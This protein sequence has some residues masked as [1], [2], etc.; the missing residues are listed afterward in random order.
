MDKKIAGLLGAVGALAAIDA[1][2][3][4]IPVNHDP[5]GS[6]KAGSYAELL[7]P[8]PNAVDVIKSDDAA[9]AASEQGSVELAQLVIREGRY[10]HHHHHH[11]QW[12][13]VVPRFMFREHHHHHH[14]HFYRRDR[15]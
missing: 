1:A 14:H 9:R 5:A 15:Y 10:H 12:R 11:H 8:V 2:H 7:D 13:R 6:L 4:A 3:A